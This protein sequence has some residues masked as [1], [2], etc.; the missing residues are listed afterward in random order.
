MARSLTPRFVRSSS[1]SPSAEIV[2][3]CQDERRVIAT[4]DT[5]DR[6]DRI[7]SARWI[8]EAQ[9]YEV[10]VSRSHGRIR[11]VRVAT[12]DLPHGEA[13]VGEAYASDPASVP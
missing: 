5:L 1:G 3:R 11:T 6:D 10:I 13:H 2:A 4:L 7:L 12:L 8:P 9:E